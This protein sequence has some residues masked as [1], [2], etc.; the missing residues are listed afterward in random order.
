[1]SSKKPGVGF[2]V[3]WMIFVVVAWLTINGNVFSF[4]GKHNTFFVVIASTVAGFAGYKAQAYTGWHPLLV[5]VMT[6][7]TSSFVFWLYA[8]GYNPFNPSVGLVKLIV[9]NS[10]VSGLSSLFF[11]LLKVIFPRSMK[12]LEDFFGLS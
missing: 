12:D 6:A 11:M 4:V 1:M 10:V 7:V 3:A 9:W 5:A 2:F 8:P